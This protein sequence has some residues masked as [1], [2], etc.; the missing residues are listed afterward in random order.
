MAETSAANCEISNANWMLQEATAQPAARNAIGVK[1]SQ[2]VSL[3]K[4]GVWN[5]LILGKFGAGDRIRTGDVQLG[6]T[7]VNWKQRTLRFLHLFLAIENTQFSFCASVG[8]LTEHKRSTAA[9]RILV[10]QELMYSIEVVQARVPDRR[11]IL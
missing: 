5:L 6:K 11:T 2:G 1:R 8:L 10:A 4:T 9:L 7:T 3:N